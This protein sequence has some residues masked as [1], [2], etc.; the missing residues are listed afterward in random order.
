MKF[1][2]LSKILYFVGS[3][4]FVVGGALNLLEEIHLDVV[5]D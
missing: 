5:T 3:M 1:S 2:M 4:C